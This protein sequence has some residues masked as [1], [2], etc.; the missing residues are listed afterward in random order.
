GEVRI[1]PVGFDASPALVAI[2]RGPQQIAIAQAERTESQASTPAQA[3]ATAAAVDGPTGD[4]MSPPG[5]S[6]ATPGRG[7]L[8][9]V[10]YY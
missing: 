8:A 10:S 6:L 3:A 7:V 1:D 4:A 9:H 5:D 2:N